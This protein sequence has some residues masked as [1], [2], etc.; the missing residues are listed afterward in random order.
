MLPQFAVWFCFEGLRKIPAPRKHR[1][2]WAG[3]SQPFLGKLLCLARKN[4]LLGQQ[5]KGLVETRASWDQGQV[6]VNTCTSLRVSSFGISLPAEIENGPPQVF[7]T[8][9]VRTLSWG[10]CLGQ[11]K[12]EKRIW[13][14]WYKSVCF[15][16]K[17]TEERVDLCFSLVWWRL[18][19]SHSVFHLCW[20]VPNRSQ[21]LCFLEINRNLTLKI[22]EGENVVH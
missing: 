22:N 18:L 20:K 1:V 8:T 11:P 10:A 14:I 13:S 15:G 5:K 12:N 7:D 9:M 3:C 6:L 16:S 21:I 19:H 2:C 17:Q 4:A